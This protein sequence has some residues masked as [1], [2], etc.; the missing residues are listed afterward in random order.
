MCMSLCANTDAS[1]QFSIAEKM[2]FKYLETA[3]AI[4]ILWQE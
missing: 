1:M 3:W 4:S 2:N